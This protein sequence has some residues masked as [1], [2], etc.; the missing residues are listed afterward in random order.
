MS[1][2]EKLG[3]VGLI[4]PS[5][6]EERISSIITVFLRSV[7]WLLLTANVVPSSPI[8]VTLMTEAIPC[9]ETSVLIEAHGVKSQKTAFF[10]VTAVKSLKS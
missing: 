7:L 8:L 1:S 10:T 2:S 9:S 3:R 6:T 4:K 5:V